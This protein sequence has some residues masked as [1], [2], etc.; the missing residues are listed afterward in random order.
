MANAATCG[1]QADA[2]ALWRKVKARDQPMGLLESALA[3]LLV[4][5]QGL[6]YQAMWY[7][8]LFLPCE[9]TPSPRPPPAGIGASLAADSLTSC[10]GCITTI[11]ALL[12]PGSRL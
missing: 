2:G 4:K 11:A 6:L 10:C 3:I 8:L 1:C 9:V 12:S 7:H 5:R